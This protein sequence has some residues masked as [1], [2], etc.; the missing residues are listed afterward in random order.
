M[1]KLVRKSFIVLL[2]VLFIFQTAA[3][4]QTIISADKLQEDFAIMRKAYTTLHPGLYRYA[5]AGTVEVYFDRLERDLKRN[6]TL[7]EAYL[8][9]SKFLAK[10]KC[11]HTYCNFWNQPDL[12]KQELFNQAD[13]VPFTFRLIDRRMIVTQN[14][15]D[16][17]RVRRGVEILAINGVPV[18]SIL[19]KLITVVKGDGSN[20]GKRLHDLQLTGNGEFE[21]FDV[22]FPLFYPL[23]KGTF[24]IKAHDLQTRKRFTFT[25]NALTR[26]Q[27]LE[28]IEKSYGKQQTNYD[29]L[30]QF[31]V[32]DNQTAYLRLGSF[33]TWKMKLDWKGF[34]N[35]SFQEI[36]QAGIK[37][38]ILDIR[39]NEGGNDEV[40]SVL[41]Q[42]LFWKP[43]RVEGTQKLLRYVKIP[44]ELDPY[45][46]TWDRSFKNR[47]NQV[48]DLGNG[49]YTLKDADARDS[50]KAASASAFRGN[51]YLLVDAANSSATFTLASLL[52]KNRLAILVGQQTGGN[53]KGLTGSQMFFLT[54]PNSKIEM[55]IPLIA[56]VPS[57]QQPDE[58]VLPDV[59]VRPKIED[60][61][62][63]IDTE[64]E[65]VRRLIAENK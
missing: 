56:T 62:R 3:L 35:T 40:V 54:L 25:A 28:T 57:N 37:H 6:L 11:G 16:D 61:F 60:I 18:K 36:E 65:A 2:V 50:E 64:M 33:V 14:A 15:S 4:S 26:S 41:G 47:E 12:V 46:N 49:F 30:W 43:V 21:A 20:D 58:G 32:L 34:L 1:R 52:K 8:A 31:K 42:Y 17:A 59:Y 63:A 10:I 48:R 53:K 23:S 7:A 44:P 24:E 9:F 45:L 27:R 38:L 55:D 19:S 29:D 51:I 5:D 22:Y 39:G 13:K